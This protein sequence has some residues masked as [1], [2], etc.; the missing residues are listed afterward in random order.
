MKYFL[1][2][3]VIVLA[4]VVAGS[5][6]CGCRRSATKVAQGYTLE[7]FNENGKYYLIASEDPLSGGGV[8]DGTIE[9]IG[10]NHDWILAQVTRLASTDTNGWYALDLKTKRVIGPIQESEL[11]TNPTLSKVECRAVEMAAGG[12]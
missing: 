3:A 11:R 4:L 9:Q 6:F 2:T 10:W 8:F 1:A 5:V 7:R 12:R